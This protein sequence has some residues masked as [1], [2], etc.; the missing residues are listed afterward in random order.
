MGLDA[1]TDKKTWNRDVQLELKS[2]G[3]S[4]HVPIGDVTDELMLDNLKKENGNFKISKKDLV[5]A[6]NETGGL[7]HWDLVATVELRC[8][9]CPA[10]IGRR[11][12]T[13]RLHEKFNVRLDR[14]EGDGRTD[15][16]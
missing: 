15:G 8:P 12:Q 5:T 14:G 13:C 1:L 7:D 10:R 3:N 9:Y 16:Q 4:W 11:R 6:W 2:F